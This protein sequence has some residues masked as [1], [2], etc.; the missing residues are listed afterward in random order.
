VVISKKEL[1][2][3]VR[4]EENL[5]FDVFVNKPLWI[6]KLICFISRN[7]RFYRAKLLKSFRYFNFYQQNRRFFFA[8]F[9]GRVYGKY[10]LLLNSQINC[11]SIGPGLKIIHQNVNINKNAVVG[12]NVL[13]TGS[14]CVGSGSYSFKW[15]R[16]TPIIGDNVQFGFGAI[17]VGGGVYC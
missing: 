12:K 6:R 5:I 11:D 13:F 3:T 4:L 16:N 10:S 1:K 14:N 7:N 17:C 9:W 15:N 2:G 8:L